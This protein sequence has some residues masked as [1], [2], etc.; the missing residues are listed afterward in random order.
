MLIRAAGITTPLPPTPPTSPLPPHDW[1]VGGTRDRGPAIKT[2]D[3]SN[4]LISGRQHRRRGAGSGFQH[5]RTTTYTPPSRRR[6][7]WA[8]STKSRSKHIA[9]R[10]THP[11]FTDHLL[12]GF[13]E[14]RYGHSARELSPRSSHTHRGPSAA[15]AFHEPTRDVPELRP[16]M[17]M[18]VLL[19]GG[20]EMASLVLTRP[21][22]SV[23]GCHVG[24]GRDAG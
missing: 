20:P 7:P 17:H 9:R 19:G 15:L 5:I 11:P 4:R 10:Q 18:H 16:R 12:L 22:S 14:S 13:E 23:L 6:L 24:L 21:R 1:C 3:R 8:A 2:Y